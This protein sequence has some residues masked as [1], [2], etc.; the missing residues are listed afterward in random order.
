MNE[1]SGETEGVASFQSV[2]VDLELLILRQKLHRLGKDVSLFLEQQTVQHFRCD[3]AQVL[4]D[5]GHG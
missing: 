2:E 3:L 4:D 1:I 5:S